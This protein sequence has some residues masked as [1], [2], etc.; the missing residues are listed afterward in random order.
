MSWILDNLETIVPIVLAVLALIDGLIQRSKKGGYLSIATVLITAIETFGQKAMKEAAKKESIKQDVK[1]PMKAL[2]AK[3][4]DEI[5]AVKR[6]EE[7]G[8][9]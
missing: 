5:K 6:A 8:A 3:V 1:Q 2:V 4:T 9:K 7:G